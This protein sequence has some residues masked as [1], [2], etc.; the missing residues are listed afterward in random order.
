MSDIGAPP[1][2]QS[3]Y[4]QAPPSFEP[5]MPICIPLE[6]LSR[7]ER[8]ALRAQNH[9]LLKNLTNTTSIV[10]GTGL[11]LVSGL[12]IGTLEQGLRILRATKLTA[13]TAGI[14][15]LVCSIVSHILLNPLAHLG[16][17]MENRRAI[18]G[19]GAEFANLYEQSVQVRKE[20]MGKQATARILGIFQSFDPTGAIGAVKAGEEA[21]LNTNYEMMRIVGVGTIKVA[22]LPMEYVIKAFVY[23]TRCLQS[24]TEKGAN[25]FGEIYQHPEELDQAVSRARHISTGAIYKGMIATDLEGAELEPI[26]KEME[27]LR[28]SSSEE[29]LK[30]FK[31]KTPEKQLKILNHVLVS[32]YCTFN[33]AE[34]FVLKK[35]I[36]KLGNREEVHPNI[37]AEENKLLSQLVITHQH[38]KLTKE[39]WSKDWSQKDFER[40][41]DIEKIKFLRTVDSHAHWYRKPIETRKKF[42]DLVHRLERTSNWPSL[43]DAE[44]KFLIKHG[45]QEFNKMKPKERVALDEFDYFEFKNLSKIDQLSIINQITEKVQSLKDEGIKLTENDK[46][47]NRVLRKLT[48]GAAI[49]H[50]RITTLLNF[51]NERFLPEEKSDMLQQLRSRVA[52][53]SI[54]Q[55]ELTKRIHETKKELALAEEQENTEEIGRC[56]ALLKLLS[57]YENQFISQA[58]VEEMQM[59]TLISSEGEPP[60]GPVE[61]QS[62]QTQKPTVQAAPESLVGTLSPQAEVVNPEGYELPS[63]K[64]LDAKVGQE[65]V[66]QGVLFASSNVMGNIAQKAIE[67]T[68]GGIV[69]KAIQYAGK[70]ISSSVVTGTLN[71]GAKVIP[72]VTLG[73]NW[74][75]QPLQ[76]ALVA[77]GLPLDQM[78]QYV[79]GAQ[80]AFYDYTMSTV[81]PKLLEAGKELSNLVVDI[82]QAAQAPQSAENLA[83][84]QAPILEKLKEY[85]T[86]LEEQCKPFEDTTK[87]SDCMQA[88]K[89]LKEAL[90]KDP[91]GVANTIA[92]L[93]NPSM[94]HEMLQSLKTQSS[95]FSKFFEEFAKQFPAHL[96]T[97]LGLIEQGAPWITP[98][99]KAI[100]ETNKGN[101]EQAWDYLSSFYTSQSN[102][103][104]G[105]KKVVKDLAELSISTRNLLKTHGDNLLAKEIIDKQAGILGYLART[106][107][108]SIQSPE[109][110][111]TAEALCRSALKMIQG[112]EALM[113][114][115]KINSMGFSV[116]DAAMTS[117]DDQVRSLQANAAK[118]TLSLAQNYEKAS[119]WNSAYS[120]GSIALGLGSFW[121]F[122]PAPLF[123]LPLL[124]NRVVPVALEETAYLLGQSQGV[125]DAL[126]STAQVGGKKA[127]EL[128]N[129]ALMKTGAYLQSKVSTEIDPERIKNFDT[130]NE[131]EQE[132]LIKIAVEVGKNPKNRSD[133]KIKE[134][135]AA[136]IEKYARNISVLTSKERKDY[137]AIV[138]KLYDSCTTSQKLEH[139]SDY[140]DLMDKRTQRRVT[141]L[142]KLHTNLSEE[143]L[144][145]PQAISSAFRSLPENI[146]TLINYLS[147]RDYLELTEEQQEDVRFLAAMSTR[148]NDYLTGAKNEVHKIC[149]NS[150]PRTY[151]DPSR[152]GIEK[153]RVDAYED[154]YGVAN[155]LEEDLTATKAFQRLEDAKHFSNNELA[156]L[157]SAYS[158]LSNEERSLIT[159]SYMRK[160]G[161]EKALHMYDIV[162]KYHPQLLSDILSKIPPTSLESR[163]KFEKILENYSKSEE[164][165]PFKF[166]IAE[167]L[168]T[169]LK[170]YIKTKK[171]EDPET[172]RLLTSFTSSEPL[173]KIRDILQY[174]FD[175]GIPVTSLTK[176]IPNF[177]FSPEQIRK[178]SQ[179]DLLEKQ[180][181]ICFEALATSFNFVPAHE[182]SQLLQFTKQEL[183][184]LPKEKLERLVIFLAQTVQDFETKMGGTILVDVL[185]DLR[186]DKPKTLGK[187]EETFNNLW[188]ELQAEFRRM[189]ASDLITG[190]QDLR[191]SAKSELEGLENKLFYTTLRYDQLLNLWQAKDLSI[192][193]LTKALDELKSTNPKALENKISKEK[194]LQ[195]KISQKLSYQRKKKEEF[196]QKIITLKAAFHIDTDSDNVSEL[197]KETGS[198]TSSLKRILRTSL[199]DVLSNELNN[200]K[201]LLQQKFTSYRTDR[202]PLPLLECKIS[203]E[204]QY[205]KRLET[206]EMELQEVTYK[207]KEL[208]A[209][210]KTPPE[211]VT[212]KDAWVAN[213]ILELRSL[214][215]F[216]LYK[217]QKKIEVLTHNNNAFKETFENEGKALK[218]TN[219]SLY[220]KLKEAFPNL[221]KRQSD[222]RDIEGKREKFLLLLP[223]NERKTCETCFKSEGTG[224]T[225]KF[226]D[227]YKDLRGNYGPP[228]K[229]YINDLIAY[230]KKYALEIPKDLQRVKDYFETP[231]EEIESEP[232][233]TEYP[234]KE[235]IE[236][237][238]EEKKKGWFKSIFSFLYRPKV[239]VES[240][241]KTE[242]I[243]PLAKDHTI[244]VEPESK[245]SRFF[246]TFFSWFSWSWKKQHKEDI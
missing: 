4:S 157:I 203:I 99:V 145:N 128:A 51:Y 8:V 126:A 223:E 154:P 156:P 221:V 105:M 83:K 18:P 232:I 65:V 21:F 6:L 122:G 245:Y 190:R 91:E 220:K 46:K 68:L 37:N 57:A 196:E 233:A 153:V 224:S 137:I 11:Q 179:F 136:F 132:S 173:K 131:N 79:I 210:I 77:R 226:V 40:L 108:A 143:E 186:S 73:G 219:S 48:N 178:C 239:K 168:E 193:E 14:L 169:E 117:V 242:S 205:N 194:E 39:K 214:E 102:I 222:K 213:K 163:E 207:I 89:R 229:A 208:K 170:E 244:K 52:I 22:A 100:E 114:V 107:L 80:K 94:A 160:L 121:L 217:I 165:Q 63:F 155:P 152:Y 174:L 33:E 98:L 180:R 66:S 162:K 200:Q 15:W 85:G 202:D 31:N 42:H 172:K 36:E 192:K 140:F 109:T 54:T 198:L 86:V 184:T 56:D 29:D 10:A 166:E 195:A 159:P 45:L 17:R 88:P 20:G 216:E 141:D 71:F 142:V 93:T 212:D 115:Q 149:E 38:I 67:G 237:L 177:T 144:E 13:G 238:P 69:P 7:E 206:C 175:K 148:Y 49:T 134:K 32:R 215:N 197:L 146:K 230:R 191:K 151:Y 187:I 44:Q 97:S 16:K 123:V 127:G 30:D 106:I 2:F 124:L 1:P 113:E 5:T 112:A 182:R 161:S 70:G 90:E 47:A 55:E 9:G 185:E 167:K 58:A 240:V 225:E 241:K 74:V 228:F 26:E 120:V 59:E 133:A 62:T 164:L 171:F 35:I 231:M 23:A 101:L 130:L 60:K 118:E 43:N 236:K 246:A 72:L 235:H 181:N 116:I 227:L 176:N 119:F 199:E 110:M 218:A 188:P 96:P 95:E 3:S 64:N 87:Y 50:L 209:N 129:F 24:M 12:T 211:E 78:D 201:L 28:P 204:E 138:L 234:L 81:V 111:K 75:M 34:K 243:P 92:V 82:S 84:A 19:L 147:V 41:D 135:H 53:V 189:E 76:A 139:T 27:Q 103:P 150:M 158:L 125:W 183:R 104:E 25:V 61:E